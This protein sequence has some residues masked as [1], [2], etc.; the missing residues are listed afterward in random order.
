MP[1]AL[2]RLLQGSLLLPT[3]ALFVA[4]LTGE[5]RHGHLW[6]E[7]PLAL[8]PGSHPASEALLAS[9]P[10]LLLFFTCCLLGLPRRHGHPAL[11]AT[12]GAAGALA[13]YCAAM[14]FAPSFGNT[15]A[16]GEIFHELYLAQWRLLALSLLPGLLGVLLLQ[17]LSRMNECPAARP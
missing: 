15:W 10:G 12:F 5:L 11:L 8:E 2:I 7:W 1:G 3:T 14:M 9:I 17:R 16:S 4:L 6:L 13:A